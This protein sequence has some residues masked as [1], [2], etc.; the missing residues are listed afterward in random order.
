MGS[1]WYER[2]LEGGPG[3]VMLALPALGQAWVLSGAQLR[4][5]VIS[6]EE[7]PVLKSSTHRTIL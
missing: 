5:Q 2:G 7:F 3:S 6:P 4:F 1:S